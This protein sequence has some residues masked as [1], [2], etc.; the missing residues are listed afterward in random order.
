M[1]IHNLVNNTKTIRA[2]NAVAAGTSA[3]NGAWIDTLGYH[4]VEF[5]AWFGTLTASQVTSAKLQYS[6]DGTNSVGDVTGSATSA[7]ADGDSNKG[8]QIE[9]YRPKHRY[10]RMVVSRGTANAVLD[11][12]QAKLFH[13]D[14]VPVTKDTT[15]ALTPEV[16][17]SPDTGTA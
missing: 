14:R 10:V 8:I 12:M 4:G 15:I 16:H 17:N 6:D 11:S 2:S 5:T 1:I 3:I 7:L 9:L 13:A